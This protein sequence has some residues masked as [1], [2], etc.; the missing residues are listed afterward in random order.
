MNII[1][2]DLYKYYETLISENKSIKEIEKVNKLIVEKEVELLENTSAASGAGGSTGTA[3][4]TT[5]GMGGVVSSQPSSMPGSLNG[6]NWISG[7]GKEGSGDIAVPY[8]PSGG[9]RAFQKVPMGKGHGA[10]TGKK[11]R[12]KRLN[13]KTLQDIF[14]KGKA[15]GGSRKVLSFK[16]YDKNKINTVTKVEEGKAF[17]ASKTPYEKKPWDNNN[18]ETFRKKVEDHVKSQGGSVKLV[19][20]DFELFISKE[21]IGQVMFR[22]EYIG[23]KKQG[24]KFINEFTYKQLGEIKKELTSIIKSH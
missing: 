16:D 2:E 1:L 5:A 8:N 20:N 21:K 11:S 13:M 17:K 15:E 14:K 6:P 22:N 19:G 18:K 4:V 10:Q 9:N 12:K 24:D 23:I 7:G 3:N